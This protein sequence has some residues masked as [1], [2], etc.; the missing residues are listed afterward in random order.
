MVRKKNEIETKSEALFGDES[1]QP[2]VE[3]PKKE[4]KKALKKL[5]WLYIEGFSREMKCTSFKPITDEELKKVDIVI[6]AIKSYKSSSREDTNWA[7]RLDLAKEK[8]PKIPEKQLELF[9]AYVPTGF[10]QTWMEES[11][12][13]VTIGGCDEITL[14]QVV[15]GTAEEIFKSK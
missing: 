9:E 3:K 8:Y 10:D 15:R 11:V 5:T 4:K 1:S 12:R 2:V 7:P 13:V 14:I 6:K